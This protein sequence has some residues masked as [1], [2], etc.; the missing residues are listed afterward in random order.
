MRNR[1][2]ERYHAGQLVHMCRVTRRGGQWHEP[3]MV[4]AVGSLGLTAG[5]HHIQVGRQLVIRAK[6]CS[7]HQRHQF[8]GVIVRKDI[9]MLPGWAMGHPFRVRTQAGARPLPAQ[10]RIGARGTVVLRSQTAL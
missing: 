5:I 4:I 9:R 10:A 8:V 2:L 3:E 7:G 6:P 1:P